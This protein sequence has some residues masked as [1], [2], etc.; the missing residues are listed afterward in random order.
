MIKFRLKPEDS[1]YSQNECQYQASFDTISN[2]WID[3]YIPFESFIAVR[4]NTVDYNAPPVNKV[5]LEGTMISLG[6]VF[7]RFSFNEQPNPK[8]TPGPF[9]L[10]VE[11]ISM[12][13]S[14]RPSIILISSAGTERINKLSSPEERARDIPIVQLN[15]QGILNWKYKAETILRES[16]LSYTII[17][18]TGLATPPAPL[19]PTISND[20]ITTTTN[21]NAVTNV[22]MNNNNIL[23]TPRRLEVFQGDSISGRITREELAELTVAALGNS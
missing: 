18:A 7:S 22:V 23:S 11:D 8:C 19:L 2:Q 15:P 5:S 1:V 9:V 21:T 6:F 16:G 20:T 12:Y 17:R 10:D 13:Q 14:K 4:R 3:V